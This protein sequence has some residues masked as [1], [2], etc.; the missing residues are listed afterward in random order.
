MKP[1]TSPG[2]MYQPSG[3]FRKVGSS[4][5]SICLEQTHWTQSLGMSEN[6]LS[7]K[8]QTQALPLNKPERVVRSQGLLGTVKMNSCLLV[9]CSQRGA[10]PNTLEGTLLRNSRACRQRQP[11]E[12]KNP[13]RNLLRMRPGAAFL[14]PSSVSLWPRLRPRP[15]FPRASC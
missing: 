7:L 11:R 12:G 15:A 5:A 3:C 2:A 8:S 1:L 6:I 13:H 4:W 14:G 10:K 9:P